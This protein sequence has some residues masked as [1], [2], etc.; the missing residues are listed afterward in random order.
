VAGDR[1]I[2]LEDPRDPRAPYA[3]DLALAAC[4]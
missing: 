2:T 4:S 3:A 1:E